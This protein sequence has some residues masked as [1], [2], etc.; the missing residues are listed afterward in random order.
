MKDARGYEICVKTTHPLVRSFAVSG[1]NAIWTRMHS[2]GMRTGRSLTVDRLPESAAGRGVSASGGCLLPRGGVCFQGVS[3]PGGGECLLWGVSQ[4]ALRQTPPVN[5]M[6]DTS[7][8]ITLATTSLRPVKIWLN[9][10]A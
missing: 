4:H 1:L 6:T 3:A 8:N 5:R 9:N 7:K 10:C 2:S